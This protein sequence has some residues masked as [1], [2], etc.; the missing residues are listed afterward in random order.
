VEQEAREE[1]AAAVYPHQAPVAAEP[2]KTVTNH[3]R[4]TA[5][6]L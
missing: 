2:A 5:A 6:S 4:S 3:R 1:Q